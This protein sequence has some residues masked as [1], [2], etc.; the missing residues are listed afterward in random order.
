MSDTRILQF[1][2][3]IE[4]PGGPDA[5][6]LMDRV[7]LELRRFTDAAAGQ[8]FV[9][10]GEEPHRLLERRALQSDG[11]VPD[12]TEQSAV[13]APDS[14]AM[15]VAL[16]REP[17]FIDDLEALPRDEP[18]RLGDDERLGFGML[19]E[20]SA[21]LPLVTAGGAVVGVVQLFNRRNGQPFEPEQ[22]AFLRPI[23][24]IVAGLIERAELMIQIA[25]QNDRLRDRNRQLA[26]SQQRIESLNALTE[27]ALM[28]S[29]ALLARAAELH[30]PTTAAH[31]RRLNLYCAALAG[32][33]GLPARFQREIG[34]SA[35]LHDVGK[36]SVDVAILRKRGPLTPAEQAEMQRHT[37]YGWEIL[38]PVRRLRMAADIAYAHHE[39]WDGS[40]YPRR[41]AG[42]AIPLAARITT[43]ADVYDALRQPRLYKNA[44]PHEAAVEI[45]LRGDERIAP[46]RH[47]DPALLATFAEHHDDF[48]QVYEQLA[49]G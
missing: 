34:F 25:R 13:A 41:L 44:L 2:E 12:Q 48:R 33:V 8:V 38:H 10:H 45:I 6:R 5:R 11:P 47:F 15:H 28:T 22:F 39:K 27:E 9:S 26:R 43:L 19:L 7:L 40:G 32:R 18:Y 42:E 29:I 49:D 17:L 3:A 1:L 21:A 37:E 20:S 35:A 4:R 16:T 23:V 14:I 36:M 24:N 31:V 30:D 46:E